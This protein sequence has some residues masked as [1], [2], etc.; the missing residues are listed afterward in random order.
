L[1]AG[2]IDA[3]HVFY[4]S[5]NP[6]ALNI[7]NLNSAQITSSFTGALSYLISA[8]VSPESEDVFALAK[9]DLLIWAKS[10]P[11]VP[12]RFRLIQSNGAPGYANDLV[13]ISEELMAIGFGNGEIM[14]LE[15]NQAYARLCGER[16]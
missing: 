8:H 11:Q 4:F 12:K 1:R 14:L 6:H 3:E 15:R 13:L 7:L 16:D 10:L 9:T 2:R 5:S